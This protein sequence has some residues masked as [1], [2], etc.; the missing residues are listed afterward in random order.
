MLTNFDC[1]ALFV[2]DRQALVQA[3]TLN[4]VYMANRATESGLVVDFKDWQVPLGRRFRAIKLWTVL[5]T[6]GAEGLRAYLRGHLAMAREFRSWVEADGRFEV[7]APTPFSLVCFRLRGDA[8][9][10]DAATRRLVDRANATGEVFLTHTVVGGRFTLRMAI[11]GAMTKR[12]H[13]RRAWDILVREL[14][15][16]GDGV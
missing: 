11:G 2:R 10:A 9:A 6:Y 1:S 16:E 4:P 13:V 5:R 14:E 8:D 7:A 3:L 12:K 15:G